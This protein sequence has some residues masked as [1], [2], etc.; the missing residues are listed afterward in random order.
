MKTFLRIILVFVPVLI[1]AVSLQAQVD[2]KEVPVE[3]RS[4][5]PENA[6]AVEQTQITSEI[7]FLQQKQWEAKKS[8]NTEDIEKIQIE[9]NKLCGSVTK[10]G[11]DAIE[12]KSS[13]ETEQTDFTSTSQ[14]TKIRTQ[15]VVNGYATASEQ[16]GTNA[17]R[18]W[19]VTCGYNGMFNRD[20]VLIYY[21]YDGY[22]W[23]LYTMFSMSANEVISYDQVDCEIIENTTGDKYLH[24]V[25]GVRNLSTGKYFIKMSSTRITSGASTFL[26]NL[27]WPGDVASNKYFRPRITSDNAAYWSNAYIYI[28]ACLDSAG[29]TGRR[30]STKLA[31]ILN[32]YTTLPT[33][34][35]KPAVMYFSYHYPTGT[36][37]HFTDLA[38]YNDVATGNESIMFVE[39]HI[40]TNLAQINFYKSSV[41]NFLITSS[42]VGSVQPNTRKRAHAYISSS[43]FS[44]ELMIVNNEFL[45][46]DV[47]VQYFKTTNSGT[48]FTS[49]FFEPAGGSK[50]S[51][52]DIVTK[53]N[54]LEHYISWSNE[55][56]PGFYEV[57]VDKFG[58]FRQTM[59]ND[60]SASNLYNLGPRAGYSPS[61]QSNLY[62]VWTELNTTFSN[63]DVWL[64]MDR[65]DQ[66]DYELKVLNFEYVSP[67]E[68]QFDIY[69]RKNGNGVM[70]Y[71]LAT[72]A[73]IINTS[74]ANGGTLSYSKVT[75][76][77]GSFVSD[78][79][80]CILSGGGMNTNA[81]NDGMS[82]TFLNISANHVRCRGVSVDNS[83]PGMRIFRMKLKTTSTNFSAESPN[84]RWKNYFPGSQTKLFT[85]RKDLNGFIYEITDSTNHFIE[86]VFVTLGMFIEGHF[87]G[88][89]NLNSPSLQMSGDTVNYYLRY[90][91]APFSIADS[92]KTLVWNNGVSHPVFTNPQLGGSYYL[93][94]K[95]R[96]SIETWSKFPVAYS[97][98]LTYNFHTS[99]SQAYGNNLKQII[100]QGD[101]VY[102]VYSGDV[103]QDG[104]IDA[105]DNGAIDND[106]FNFVQGY[107]NTDLT[108]DNVVD[109]S[110]A[111]IANN[112]ASNFVQKIVP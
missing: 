85:Y 55:T 90:P 49:G 14:S 80:E 81:S 110:D 16:I 33:I 57:I 42:I 32:P 45:S 91:Q 19:T 107:V 30:A 21:S 46:S 4:I 65:V 105:T 71:G 6:S 40:G 54:S 41:S 25:Y 79:S 69:L 60:S 109:A 5:I 36:V 31:Q 23:N 67:N 78:L 88:G 22:V 73:L 34:T 76:S 72:F 102:A 53:R 38:F 93:V 50:C 100:V 39:S 68:L 92:S 10:K 64:S 27:T 94:V 70:E 51:R 37:S 101:T 82:S 74:F 44:T 12:T 83:S 2:Y 97:D 24:V 26:F 86:Y 35:Y 111:A 89:M 108:G 56:S 84:V 8:G 106:A 15:S 103:N 43:G 13:F 17:G 7:L 59:L 20:S 29:S 112:N 11:E 3:L 66:T 62:A 98:S 9:L 95:H 52:P 28:S 47:Y 58:W 1:F 96:N 77:G 48:N 18:I 87:S 104:V 75:N 63:N 99:A 61:L